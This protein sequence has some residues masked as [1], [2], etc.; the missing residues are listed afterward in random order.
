MIGDGERGG[1]GLDASECVWR[2][3][4]MEDGGWMDG[5]V[6]WGK[7]F[8]RSPRLFQ[9]VYMIKGGGHRAFVFTAVFSPYV[10]STVMAGCKRLFLRRKAGSALGFYCDILVVSVLRLRWNLGGCVC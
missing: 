4:Y 5:L 9:P 3:C 10:G 6:G 2:F 8:L 1:Y 7:T